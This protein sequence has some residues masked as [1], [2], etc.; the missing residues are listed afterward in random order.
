MR[1][2]AKTIKF[3]CDIHE[4]LYCAKNEKIAKKYLINCNKH[5]LPTL[6]IMTCLQIFKIFKVWQKVNLMNSFFFSK[7]TNWKIM[8]CILL[9]LCFFHQKFHYYCSF[10]Y[11]ILLI[12]IYPFSLFIIL[13]TAPLVSWSSQRGEE[14]IVIS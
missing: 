11:F 10:I 7:R 1:L 13:A 2:G 8:P 6:T 4:W 3:L 5:F 14:W 12:L 9:F